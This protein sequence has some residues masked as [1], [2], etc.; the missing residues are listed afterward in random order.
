MSG[1]VD[2]RL[3]S[4]S[5]AARRHMGLAG[6]LGVASAGLTIAQAALLAH[7]IATAAIGHATLASLRPYLIALAGVMLG[8]AAVTAGFE[9]CG[10]LG[11][12][13]V[14]SELRGRLARHVL[15][16]STG[17]RSDEMRTGELATV[18]VQG[19]DSL[20]AY[21]AGYLPQLVMAALLP[22]AILCWAAVID[23]AAAAVLA[24]TI[25]ILIV[26]MVL[27]GKRARA[28]TD[29]RWRA[30]S[31]L[32]A[33]FLDV[34]RGLPTLR[35]YRRE[36]AQARTLAA[37][38]ERYRAETMATLRV[39]FLSALVLE[40]CAMIGTAL[41]AATIGL[42]LV[43]GHLGLTAGLTV[44]LLAP[45]LYG[46]LRGVGQQYHASAEATAAAQR[47]FDTLD[48]PP[49]LDGPRDRAA[50]LPDPSRD[51][52]RLHGVRFEYPRRPGLALDGVEMEIAP[53]QVTALVGDSGAG[54]ST[55]ARL[56]MR[57]ADPTEGKVSCGGV[58]LR[59]I[60]PERWHELIAWV[61]QRPALFAG[62]VAEN[63]RLGAPDASDLRVRRAARAANALEF[64]EQLP[65]GMQTRLGDGGRRLS[66]GQAQRIALARAFLREAPLVVLDEP[67]AHL[68]EAGA[69]QV[70]EAIERLAAGRTMLLIVHRPSL[71][72]RADHILR[73]EGGRLAGADART[74]AGGLAA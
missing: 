61:P 51:P 58:D 30:L 3:L 9:L 71:A 14:M 25:P 35:A 31:L 41:A 38:G 68:D 36:L 19:V 34:V 8:R 4:E 10:R 5:S 47:I 39:A 65:E 20:E 1:A 72:L 63:I 26:F 46:P 50:R 66:A 67:T 24:L 13:R 37:V 60:E 43:G 64:I 54:K 53:G 32:G 40:L 48:A 57:M 69:A 28:Q 18:A 49:A 44:L 6:A 12:G 27:V 15:A 42:Q 2:R 17:G 16:T 29:R 73:L 22:P 70:S 45:E 23:P 55:V 11:A 62:T 52:V 74:C 56:V 7:V 59:A 21:F 33:H